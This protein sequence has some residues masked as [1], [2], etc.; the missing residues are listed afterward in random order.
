ML[1][2]N[3]YEDNQDD[4]TKLNEI[5]TKINATLEEITLHFEE[6]SKLKNNDREVLAL[7]A[8]F[9]SE[10]LNDKAKAKIYKTRLSE[11]EGSKMYNEEENKAN[12]D[13]NFVS[14]NDDF[15]YM[16]LSANIH[17]IGLIM[18]ASLGVC[19]IFGYTKE[20]L[21]GKDID[22]L[23]PEQ[24]QKTHKMMLTERLNE[25]KKHVAN[26]HHTQ[27]N[28]NNNNKTNTANAKFMDIQVF[29]KNKSRYLVPLNMSVALL[30][31]DQNDETYFAAKIFKDE[32]LKEQ[33]MASKVCYVL[34]DQNFVL[35]YFTSNA[36]KML[37]LDFK[38]SGNLDITR[39]IKELDDV[40]QPDLLGGQTLE[41][42]LNYKKQITSGRF[43][44]PGK[45]KWRIT[46][47]EEDD[48]DEISYDISSHRTP[49][50]FRK[51]SKMNLKGFKFLSVDMSLV[52]T[53][54][55]LMGKCKGHIFKFERIDIKDQT[56][57]KLGQILDPNKIDQSFVPKDY[58]S[59]HVD[60]D[61]KSFLVNPKD[62]IALRENLKGKA[63]RRLNIGN[64][65]DNMAVQESQNDSSS[66]SG[67]GSS[68][69]SSDSRSSDDQESNSEEDSRRN[70]L[71]VTKISGVPLIK[72]GGEDSEYYKVNL[73]KIKFFVY[74]MKKDVLIEVNDNNRVSQV[75]YK[76]HEDHKIAMKIQNMREQSNHHSPSKQIKDNSD[77][78]GSNGDL[79]NDDI[80]LKQ[81]EYALAKKDNQSEM[82]F[83]RWVLGLGF[84][85]L[86][87]FLIV[88]IVLF[89]NIEQYI[90]YG[91]S[92]TVYSCKLLSNS[93][94]GAF[95]SRE[96]TL[97]NNRN[98]TNYLQP[99]SEY[100][101][102]ITGE[103]GLLFSSSY[104]LFANITSTKS[105]SEGNGTNSF[106]SEILQVN[107]LENNQLIHK[108]NLDFSSAFTEMNT[109]LF[110]ISSS[111]IDLLNSTNSD[112]YFFIYNNYNTMLSVLQNHI[113]YSL[114]EL[115]TKI[116]D[117]NSGLIIFVVVV[118]VVFIVF[119]FFRH[120]TYAN[121]LLRRES[122]LEVFFQIGEDVIKRS[123]KKC[124]E[125]N[126][127]AQLDEQS[128]GMSMFAD[129]ESI[130]L[131][132]SRDLITGNHKHGMSH[133]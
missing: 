33:M 97:L 119:N 29:G 39:M 131:S 65:P 26:N 8:D 87:L 27:L 96:L 114:D 79:N 118:F 3:P 80:L 60:P 125:F 40:K 116:K 52:I 124:E 16:I 12:F 104:N 37:K 102:N 120:K 105:F 9:L 2:L 72:G 123:L 18:K 49:N 44:T 112:I 132:D 31:T 70:D 121:V 78:S 43:R 35:Q 6:M 107:I 133:F 69:N 94:K 86:M 59:F 75:Q 117:S 106:N 55:L 109:A 129:E 13:I 93:L 14:T 115:N 46:N 25:Y 85:S 62:T 58:I 77:D 28:N 22:L 63:I 98:Y 108:A 127:K 91:F 32:A 15:Q 126:K 19:A 111:N 64:T 73:S 76:K 47:D 4:I 36:I 113:F 56:S 11:V 50:Q 45:I 5:G 34:T 67:S 48:I 74:D 66:S 88:F 99:R 82:T 20:E 51:E 42:F 103:L 130:E 53:D 71:G 23:I 68:S 24:F 7:Y 84:L 1:L 41:E 95:Y 122:Y 61:R 81:I 100:I 17:N 110:H 38:Y 10:I 83:Y 57:Q 101:A 89:V 30:P 92:L 54:V 21:L 90:S 128:E